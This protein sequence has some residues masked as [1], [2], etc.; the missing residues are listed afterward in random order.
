M[1]CT[2]ECFVHI[3]HEQWNA[4][5]GLP[6]KHFPATSLLLSGQWYLTGFVPV[7]WGRRFARKN[8]SCRRLV[9]VRY[10]LHAH[11]KN[12]ATVVTSC[13]R[14]VKVLSL[15]NDK[16]HWFGSLGTSSIVDNA[17]I[18][19]F[20]AL[21][22]TGNQQWS[23]ITIR[24]LLMKW[25]PLL[26]ATILNWFPLPLV[27]QRLCSRGLDG[28]YHRFAKRNIHWL[29]W[30]VSDSGWYTYIKDIKWCVSLEKFQAWVYNLL[31]YFLNE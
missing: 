23:T 16:F 1:V 21:L 5:L 28:E 8:L 4:L 18:Y 7:A 17:A 3:H 6:A 2:K 10:I 11:G 25:L 31:Q 15:T 13:T 12:W 24:P 9:I 26:T 14:A 19:S 22:R 29:L 20:I 30:M 27:V